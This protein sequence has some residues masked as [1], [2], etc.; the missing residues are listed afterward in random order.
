VSI[1]NPYRTAVTKINVTGMAIIL[2]IR[3]LAN[4]GINIFSNNPV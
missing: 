2:R 3:N 4:G 1:S